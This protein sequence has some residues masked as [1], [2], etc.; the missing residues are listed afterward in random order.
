MSATALAAYQVEAYNTA[1]A[2]ENKIHD[3]EVARRFGFAGGLVPGVDVYG[4]MSH[5]AVQRWG[6]DWLARG[7]AECRFVKPV[8]DGETATVTAVE[9]NGGLDIAVESRGVPCA[10]GQ[11]WMTDAP[12][13]PRLGA[14][15]VASPPAVRPP[16]GERTLAVDTRLGMAPF[17]LTPD[18]AERYLH[19]VR[20]TD[21][22]YARDGLAHPGMILRL[23]NWTLMH[24]VVL[25]PWIHVGSKVQNFSA[26]RVGDDLSVRARVTDNYERKGHRFVDLDALVIANGR[27]AVARVLH[28][29]IYRPRQVAEAE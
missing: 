6:R 27:T 2:S 17:R 20:E 18:Y 3:S 22:V 19:D 5:P 21:P 24:N 15:T 26:A 10:G 1:H 7:R 4:Y 25:G 29:A 11:A 28:T 23:C 13:P 16:A 9:C 12:A 8:Y 14:F